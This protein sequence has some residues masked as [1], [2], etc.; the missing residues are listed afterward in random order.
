MASYHII[1]YHP[2]ILGESFSNRYEYLLAKIGFDTAVDEP[3]KICPLRLQIAQV[4]SI[5]RI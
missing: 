1:S 4:A 3:C 2:I 5:T